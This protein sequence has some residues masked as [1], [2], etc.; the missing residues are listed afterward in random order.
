MKAFCAS[1][2]VRRIFDLGETLGLLHEVHIDRFRARVVLRADHSP[3]VLVL[4]QHHVIRHLWRVEKQT[5]A[6][7]GVIRRAQL[8]EL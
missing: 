5:R 1:I 7:A 2:W 6:V 8:D 4:E 3:E